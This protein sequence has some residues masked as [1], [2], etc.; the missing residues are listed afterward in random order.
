MFERPPSSFVGKR[1][2]R[3]YLAY[4]TE[5]SEGV[6]KQQEPPFFT[7]N[8]LSQHFQKEEGTTESR[9]TS[10]FKKRPINIITDSKY[11]SIDVYTKEEEALKKNNHRTRNH[12]LF[13]KGFKIEHLR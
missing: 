1:S 4:T 10:A 12:H 9:R 2:N 7:L 13:S 5:L 8:F 11:I 3:I 6:K